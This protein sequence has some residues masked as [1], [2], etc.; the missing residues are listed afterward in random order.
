M[1]KIAVIT[2]ADGGMGSEIT[3]EVAA[4]GYKTIMLCQTKG[5]GEERKRQIIE[6]TGN[7][8]IEV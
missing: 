3:R 7:T 4:A 2:G 8:D 6:Q 1:N 5:K